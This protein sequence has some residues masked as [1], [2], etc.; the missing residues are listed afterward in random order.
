MSATNSQASELPAVIAALYEN[1]AF[2]C[3]QGDDGRCVHPTGRLLE[4]LSL[5]ARIRYLA[6]R[7]VTQQL[8]RE[9]GGSV[10]QGLK[11]AESRRFLLALL[12]LRLCVLR[13]R[14]RGNGLILPHQLEETKLEPLDP[15]HLE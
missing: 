4:V 5:V 1:T 13:A 14:L 3:H 10:A 15:L 9:N 7:A 6:L 12:L 11:M 8:D 2:K